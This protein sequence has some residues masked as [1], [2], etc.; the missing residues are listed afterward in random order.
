MK[1]FNLVAKFPEVLG[2]AISDSSGALLDCVGQMDGEVAGAVHAFTARA[3][4]QVGEILGLSSF[5]RAT[6]TGPSF[7]CLIATYDNS[8]L[9]V[10]ID[11]HRPLNVVEKKIW[12]TISK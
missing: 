12:E 8:V 10:D 4:T 6:I 5:E 3:L 2:A 9:G 11:P 1:N 7:A